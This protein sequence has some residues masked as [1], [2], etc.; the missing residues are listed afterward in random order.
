M[1]LQ[2]TIVSATR[3]VL[4]AA[5]GRNLIERHQAREYG[6]EIED[7]RLLATNPTGTP[8]SVHNPTPQSEQPISLR[9]PSGGHLAA[10]YR[11]LV[12]TFTY[13]KRRPLLF[14]YLK[15]LTEPPAA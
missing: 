5:P 2:Q 4:G 15:A 7:T 8:L 11:L 12:L 10:Q 9:K 1:P 6:L 14:S 13:L 3:P